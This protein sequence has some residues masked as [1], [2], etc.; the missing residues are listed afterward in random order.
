[1][2]PEGKIKKAV[3]LIIDPRRPRLYYEMPV[4]TGF[5]KSGLDFSCCYFGLAF[6][7]ETKAP[8]EQLRPLQR[9]RAVDMLTSGA[10]VFVISR[11]EGMQALERWLV[12]VED[13]F[14]RSWRK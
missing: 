3:K 14:A 11:L 7:I 6:Y 9:Q 8:G 4:P 10:R 13:A 1:M 12:R 2:T 5:G